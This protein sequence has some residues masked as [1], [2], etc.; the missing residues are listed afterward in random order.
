MMSFVHPPQQN[1]FDELRF[2]REEWGGICSAHPNVLVVGEKVDTAAAL[3]VLGV[4]HRLPVVVWNCGSARLTR[5]PSQNVGT[6]ILN[7]VAA[8]SLE[9]QRVLCEWLDDARG[10]FQV[11]TTSAEPL[12]PLVKN[13]AFLEVLYYRLNVVY[14]ELTSRAATTGRSGR[15][16]ISADDER[17]G[18]SADR[19]GKRR[20]PRIE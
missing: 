3:K 17:R 10:R 2:L 14:A 15:S 1:G 13:G 5:P 18:R 11:V 4:G 6:L 19:R 20:H 8:L 9:E 7:D 16:G 12:L